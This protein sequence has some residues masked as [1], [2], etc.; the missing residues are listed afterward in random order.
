MKAYGVVNVQ[1]HVFLT[2]TLTGGE[3]SVSRPGRFTPGT[4][5]TG[6]WVGSR[7]GLDDVE[8]GKVIYSTGT[9]NP[10]PRSFSPYLVAI[11]TALSRK[12]TAIRTKYLHMKKYKITSGVVIGKEVRLIVPRVHCYFTCLYT[13]RSRRG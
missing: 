6:G 10:T 5:W 13:C 2:S 3:W 11:P 1:I 9:R 8:R 7:A 12:P 4:H